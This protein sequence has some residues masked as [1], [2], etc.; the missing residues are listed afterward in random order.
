MTLKLEDKGLCSVLNLETTRALYI[1]LGW[2]A[3][4]APP[5]LFPKVLGKLVLVITDESEI[6]PESSWFVVSTNLFS[7]GYF[8]LSLIYIYIVDKFREIQ[9]RAYIKNSRFEIHKSIK[10]MPLVP[11]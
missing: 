7:M 4:H 10:A 6:K 11:L 3:L 8:L 9:I 1:E 2:S 5:A